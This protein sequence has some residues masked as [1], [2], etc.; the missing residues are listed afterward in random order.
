MLDR[1]IHLESSGAGTEGEGSGDGEKGGKEEPPAPTPKP[2]TGTEEETV[3]KSQLEQANAE[4]AKRR[5]ELREAEK[6]I[7]E[8]EGKDKTEAE[9]LQGERDTAAKERD[10]AQT[11]NRALRARV[12]ASAAGIADPKAAADAAS[13][14]DWTKIEDPTDDSQVEKALVDLVKDRPYLAGNV[15]GGSDG[16]AGGQRGQGGEGMN[17]L[18]RGASGR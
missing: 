2:E 10:D 8:L 17:A 7:A 3:P 11:E 1:I 12:L 4:A 15:A 6:K 5:R 13:L 18:I 14:L 16:G 9:R